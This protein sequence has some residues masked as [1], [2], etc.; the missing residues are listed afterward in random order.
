MPRFLDTDGITYLWNK[1]SLQDYPNNQ[2]LVAVI[3]AIDANKA[4]KNYET[5]TFTLAD[6]TTVTKQVCVSNG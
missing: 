2:T 6:G 5:W 1:I 4:D 3:N